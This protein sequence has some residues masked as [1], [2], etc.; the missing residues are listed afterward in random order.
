MIRAQDTPSRWPL[1]VVIIAA[2]VVHAALG[3]GLATWKGRM[4]V[5]AERS[6]DSA[7]YLALADNLREHH[8]FSRGCSLP[9]RPSATA[10]P[11]PR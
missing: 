11:L 5:L 4:D 8:A 7:E 10:G 6:V 3:V 1:W 9:C 2:I